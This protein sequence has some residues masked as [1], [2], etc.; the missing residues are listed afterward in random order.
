MKEQEPLDNSGLA[1]LIIFL[2]F[3]AGIVYA[4]YQLDC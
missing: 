1:E 4:I 2:F 3:F